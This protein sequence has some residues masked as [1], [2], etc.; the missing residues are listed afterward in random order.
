MTPELIAKAIIVITIADFLCHLFY[1]H[2]CKK[3]ALHRLILQYIRDSFQ[4]EYDYLEACHALIR[5]T[6]KKNVK[7]KFRKK[8]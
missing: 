2:Y 6:C 4:N 3:K 5:N 7:K 1:K 8:G